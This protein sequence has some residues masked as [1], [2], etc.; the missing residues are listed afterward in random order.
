MEI[1][2]LK[3][4]RSHVFLVLALLSLFGVYLAYERQPQPEAT[5][6]VASAETE[7]ALPPTATP[8]AQIRV[9]VVGAVTAPGV[10]T[11]GEDARIVDAVQAAGGL[12]EEADPEGVNLADRLGDGQQVR[13]PARGATPQPSLTPMLADAGSIATGASSASG[14]GLIN[15]NT[16]SA[17]E[18]EQL[19]GIGPVL[20]ARIVEDR[21]QNGSFATTAEIMRVSGIGEAIY[22]RIRDQV[23]VQ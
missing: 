20:A 8:T 10:Y 3:E 18:L 23:T 13:V 21:Q 11:L 4:Y 22:E 12:T 2:S 16:A 6:C 19:S 15:L 17:T 5:I 7:E 1:G 14:P 9:H